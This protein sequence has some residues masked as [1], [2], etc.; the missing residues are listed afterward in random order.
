MLQFPWPGAWPEEPAHSL[1][2]SRGVRARAPSSRGPADG[3]LGIG[4]ST[5]GGGGDW[6]EGGR[7]DDFGDLGVGN[8]MKRRRE[9]YDVRATT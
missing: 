8:R 7:G 6:M 5:E 4:D 1:A 3:D 9:G 2:V